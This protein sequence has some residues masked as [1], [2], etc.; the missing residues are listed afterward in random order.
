MSAQKK[1]DTTKG[2]VPPVNKKMDSA[3]TFIEA[4]NTP[5]GVALTIL[6]SL[7]LGVALGKVGLNILFPLGHSRSPL[8]PASDRARSASTA[9]ISTPRRPDSTA[10]A[11]VPASDR[12]ASAST[13]P[14]SAPPPLVPTIAVASVSAPR[15]PDSTATASVPVSDGAEPASTAP[16][17]AP[18][19][20]TPTVAAPAALVP[21]PPRPNSTDAM[22][23]RQAQLFKRG[24]DFLKD[25]NVAA[26]RLMLQSVADAGNAQAALLLG[27]T[28]D[29]IMLAD[30]GV[31]GL[32]PDRVAALAWYRRAQEYGAS[33]ALGRIKRLMEADR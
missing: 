12:A 6:F 3:R 13:A 16:A 10:A 7:A 31:R 18:L 22:S 27:A 8:V 28:Y 33:E 15:R 23:D 30:L 11:L 17:S 4:A 19:P 21:A 20:P 5:F 14:I 24:A 26:A 1:S 25:G 9:P 29:P 32:Q 2:L